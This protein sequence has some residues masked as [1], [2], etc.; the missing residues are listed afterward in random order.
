[1]RLSVS[2]VNGKGPTMNISAMRFSLGVLFLILGGVILARRWLMPE[3]FAGYDPV[4]LNLG[5]VLALVFGGLN[6]ARWYAA[7]IVR[8]SARAP[9][10]IP[11]QRD[12]SAAPQD[13]PNPEFDFFKKPETGREEAN[14]G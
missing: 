7:R 5:G 12:P 9:V 10:R 6:L 4:R 11:L 14:N 2:T 3:A 8:Q 13:E 1:M